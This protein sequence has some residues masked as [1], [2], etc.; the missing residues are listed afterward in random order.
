MD[1]DNRHSLTIRIQARDGTPLSKLIK[2]FNS[3][4][5]KEMREEIISLLMAS[6][7]YALEV[8]EEN[9]DNVERCYWQTLNQLFYYAYCMMQTLGI[10]SKAPATNLFGPHLFFE[11]KIAGQVVEAEAKIEP[12][13]EPELEEDEEIDF[14]SSLGIAQ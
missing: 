4:P 12:E 7:P 6:M 9:P 5:K 11:S 14:M 2:R 3:M 8:A 13:P 10:K 1:K